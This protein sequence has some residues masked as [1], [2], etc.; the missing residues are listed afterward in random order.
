VYVG[1]SPEGGRVVL[2]SPDQEADLWMWD[3]AR[4]TLTRLTFT[5]GVDI[6][7]VWSP[8]GRRVVFSSEREGARNLFSQAADGTGAIDRLTR[9]PN[10]QNATAVSPDGT[11][12]IFTETAPTTGED[13]MQ[14]EMAGTHAVT[15]LVQS[16]FAERN[17]IV[18]PDGRWLAYEA[19][20]S[21]QVEIYVRPYPNVNAGRWQVSTGGGTRPLWSRTGQ[22]LFYVSP[23]GGIVRIGVERGTSWAATTP[24]TIVKEGYLPSLP[25]VFPGRSYDVSAD[26]QRFLVLKPVSAPNAPPPQI[27]VVQHFDEELKRLVPT[28]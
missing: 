18:S 12:L 16:P 11:R 1:V 19:N 9:S 21:G 8:D 4:L 5:P 15:P 23:A 10:Q 28:N 2:Y 6:Y 3:V 17:G 26:G 24:V 13:V 7:P 14:V 22:E 27:V 25:G 20:D